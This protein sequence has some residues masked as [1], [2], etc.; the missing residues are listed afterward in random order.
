MRDPG[1][2]G[3]HGIRMLSRQAQQL[4]REPEPHR[5]FSARRIPKDALHSTI[6]E[7]VWAS[8]TEAENKYTSLKPSEGCRGRGSR[9]GAAHREGH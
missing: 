2:I 6:R 5:A 3:P 8:I 4:A 1:W 9:D 7:D